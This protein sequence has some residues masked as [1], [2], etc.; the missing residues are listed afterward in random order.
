[1]TLLES[2]PWKDPKYPYV[3]EDDD[4]KLIRK[5]AFD[6]FSKIE[7][8]VNDYHQRYH[9]QHNDKSDWHSVRLKKS[10]LRNCE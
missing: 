7:G 4:D 1:M 10:K 6:C 2:Y 9:N 8:S 5:L 3:N